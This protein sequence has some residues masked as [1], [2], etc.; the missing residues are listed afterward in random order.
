MQRS[1]P[2]ATT[3][4][5]ATL[6]AV[7]PSARKAVAD[8]LSAV[9]ALAQLFREGGYRLYLVGGVVREA[10]AGKFDALTDLDCTTDAHPPEVRRIV[11]SLATAV[12]TQGERFGTIG[13]T[14][15][16][17]DYE[18]TTH[19]ADY[20]LSDSRKPLVT[21][22]DDV[23]ADL[24]RR[25]FTVNAMAVDT[26][27]GTLIDPYGGYVDLQAQVLRT[28]LDPTVSFADDPLRMLRAARFIASHS[29]N[30]EPNL[31]N[32][33]QSMTDRIDIVAVERIRDEFQK[34][35][36]QSHPIEG[37]Q[38]LAATGLIT[39]LIPELNSLRLEESAHV[40]AAVAAD[41][42]SRWAA[43]FVNDSPETASL[44]L[45]RMRCSR[46]LTTSVS[47]LLQAR[48]D[49]I[50][51][52]ATRANVRRFVHSCSVP[53][54]D[55]LAFASAVAKA[56]DTDQTAQSTNL[57]GAFAESLVELRA[58]EDLDMLVLPLD[59]TEIM[60]ALAIEAGPEVGRA[61]DFLRNK[62]FE[63]GPLSKPEALAALELWSA[64]ELRF[65][66]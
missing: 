63:Q 42:V 11:D 57:L 36:L 53:I 24:A 3:K 31:V 19:R 35:L 38:F 13:C 37:F 43:L 58:N 28:P 64:H 66:S 30:P 34:L 54:D 26:A 65:K 59:G 4:G 17:R 1:E 25:D 47:A 12:W 50:G 45:C 62:T 32:A 48:L 5:Q 55:V 52:P 56:S 23:A 44:S 18:I 21:F 39:R 49:L 15:G 46:S 8:A 2:S 61:L 16:D 7:L 33:V 9:D 14:V 6:A 29:L 22:G 10:V 40:V 20:Y 27:D 41:L 51:T 60:A